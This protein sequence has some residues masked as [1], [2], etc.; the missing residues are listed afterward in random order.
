MDHMFSQCLIDCKLQAFD[1]FQIDKLTFYTKI[2]RA[3]FEWKIAALTWAIMACKQTSVLE[4]LGGQAR[5]CCKM[6]KGN[7]SFVCY[8]WSPETMAAGYQRHPSAE[9]GRE[10]MVCSSL[11]RFVVSLWLVAW[12]RREKN[13]F[14]YSADLQELFIVILIFVLCIYNS[15]GF[16]LRE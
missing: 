12:G 1:N 14:L 9:K 13:Y 4:K 2:F 5:W 8:C 16:F 11:L 10:E 7:S 3:N 6:N 15:V